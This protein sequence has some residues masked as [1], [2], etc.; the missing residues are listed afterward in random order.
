MTLKICRHHERW[1]FDIAAPTFD[2]L[3]SRWLIKAKF[4]LNIWHL[5][6]LYRNTPDNARIESWY[7]QLLDIST[8]DKFHAVLVHFPIGAFP[9]LFFFN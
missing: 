5:G 9:E 7:V 1:D 8:D 6:V 3:G 4:M 2:A